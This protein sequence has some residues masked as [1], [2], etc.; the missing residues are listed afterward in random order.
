M[1]QA[2]ALITPALAEVQSRFNDWRKKRKHRNPIPE[3]LWTAAVMLTQEH[4][5]N[6]V[7]KTL[8]LSYAALKERIKQH[9][10]CKS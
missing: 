2:P 10:F 1:E 4:S 9:L 5:L 6:K 8:H 3:E 7:S